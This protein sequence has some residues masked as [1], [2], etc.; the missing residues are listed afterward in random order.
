MQ[1]GAAL[2]L[3]YLPPSAPLPRT[4]QQDGR[5]PLHAAARHAAAAD[6]VEILLRAFPRGARQKDYVRRSPAPA[7]LSWACVR[8][9]NK[10][11]NRSS[12]RLLHSRF[13]SLH[14]ECSTLTMSACLPRSMHGVFRLTC[15]AQRR[16]LPLHFALEH[17]ASERVVALLLQ[18][19]PKGVQLKNEVRQLCCGVKQG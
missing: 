12:R 11:Q 14:A 13:S 19:F 17:K 7:I 1:H 5:L 8:A 16:L 3:W 6:V 9:G 4:L 18:F 15:V 10:V 2:Q